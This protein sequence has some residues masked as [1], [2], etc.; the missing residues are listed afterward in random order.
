M[1]YERGNAAKQWILNEMG[2]HF[3]GSACRVL[4]LGCGDGAKWRGFLPTHPVMTVVGIDTD[5]EAIAR[6]RGM[7]AGLKGLD[8]R[9]ADAQKPVEGAFDV[10]VAMSAIEH[11]VDRKAFLTTVWDALSSGGVA[12][13]N[14]DAG[15]FRSRDIKERLM[16][17]I[18][19]LL[20]LIGVEGPYMKKVDDATF[21]RQAEAQGFKVVATRKHN[22]APLKGV[23]RGAGD[24][25]LV[26][27]FAYEEALNA[28]FA[29]EQL[30]GAM[31]S[32]TLILQKP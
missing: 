24:E 27:W 19:Q 28:R 10:I 22:L 9:V 21:R 3:G 5:A 31:W 18:S 17:P 20:A 13:L 30:D 1:I 32:T 12:F 2:R 7:S 23:M 8:L 11:V 14:Y 4:D 15:H 6:G 29:P 26:E 25:A 16:V